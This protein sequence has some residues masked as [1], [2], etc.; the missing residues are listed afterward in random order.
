M[1]TLWHWNTFD[2][3]VSL[4]GET[5]SHRCLPNKRPIMQTFDVSSWTN[6]DFFNWTQKSWA[7]Y[8]PFY[9]S[10][11]VLS[12]HLGSRDLCLLEVVQTA[13]VLTCARSILGLKHSS[14]AVLPT[15]K[16]HYKVY[17]TRRWL[18]QCLRCRFHA[19]YI[20]IYIFVQICLA[21][22]HYY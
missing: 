1:I 14:S 11:I 18:P 22:D 10:F 4:W 9:F 12:Q 19:N 16:H 7:K 6:V 8:R 3:I 13:L 21:S 2:I 15:D 20:Y 17:L 5:T